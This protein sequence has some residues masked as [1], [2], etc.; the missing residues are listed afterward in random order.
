MGRPLGLA[1]A[2]I[3]GF[4]I[5]YFN[6]VTPRPAPLD[7]PAADFSASRA[8][9]DIR[10]MGSTPHVLGSPEDAEVRD[11]LVARMT[12]LGLSPHVEHG[13]SFEAHGSVVS[14]GA[15]DNV[16]GVLPGRDRNAPAL[17]FMAHHDSVRGSPGAADDTAGVASALEMIR[18][19]E[20]KGTP[21]RDVMLVITDGEEA[22]LLGA[23]AFFEQSPLAAHV[24][25]VI[26]METRG[27][28]G[29]V[30][31]FETASDNG[32]DIGLY[33][34]TAERPQSNALTVFVYKH[35]Q[36]DTDFT[37]AKAHGKVGLNY[38]FIGRQFDYHSPS[39]TPDVLDQGSLQHMGSQILP[40]AEA[41]AFGPLP[42]RAPDVIYGNVPGGLTLVYP[43][44]GGW[45]VL[46]GAGGLIALGAW[47]ART[48]DEFVFA[49][50]A[51]GMGASLYVL[52]AGVA[53]LELVR[54]ATGVGAGWMPYRPILARFP[55]FELMMLAAALGVVIAASTFSN[56]G[57]RT[58]WI[59]AGAA[60]VAGIGACLFGG[61]DTIGLGAGVIGAVLG[62]ASF[63]APGKVAGSWTGLLVAALIFAGVAQAFA[64][65]AYLRIITPLSPY[66][67]A[68]HRRR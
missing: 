42:A 28:G 29:L 38:A 37:V 7:A 40:T 32:G 55:L 66:D 45:L 21:D 36:N 51:R 25:Y 65:T 24:G 8:M 43:A 59:T 34:R 63:G 22:G 4:L 2:L 17:A 56:K 20:T 58:R 57:G 31:M 60:L 19:I 6:T 16:I 49:D 5:F 61:L 33:R 35:M 9:V 1:V 53:V 52:F 10:A 54:R 50:M 46:I 39:S 12:A 30:Q 62:V 68:L 15:V 44:W 47:R 67:N 48:R 23:R 3:A 26:N 18:A 13:A 41:L 27:G 64:P 11:Y 14:G